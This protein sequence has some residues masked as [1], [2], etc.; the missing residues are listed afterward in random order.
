M[1]RE[2]SLH[3]SGSFIQ[4]ARRSTFH[5][6]GR[7]KHR[8]THQSE[9]ISEKERN[10]VYK[11]EDKELK[12]DQTTPYT[13][14]AAPDARIWGLYL[15]EAEAEDKELMEPWNKDLDSLLIFVSTAYT[16]TLDI[17]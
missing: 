7:E 10:I 2:V 4:R 11:N 5:L 9:Q 1:Q 8:K 15:E 17:S 6:G 13:R 16:S 14:Y 3:L 12:H